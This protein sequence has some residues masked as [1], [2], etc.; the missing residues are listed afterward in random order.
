MKKILSIKF[1][2]GIIVILGIGLLAYW[3]FIATCCRTITPE[4][5]AKKRCLVLATDY[6]GKLVSNNFN[7]NKSFEQ[8]EECK[9]LIPIVDEKYCKELLG[10]Q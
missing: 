1:V 10:I 4:E 3:F 2:V 9:K 6:C 8:D 7:L 5:Y